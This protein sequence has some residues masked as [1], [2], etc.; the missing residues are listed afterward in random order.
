MTVPG[1]NAITRS[2]IPVKIIRW[3]NHERTDALAE[4]IS[5]Y[6]GT[7]HL[8]RSDLIV[9]PDVAMSLL[10]PDEVKSDT[11][12]NKSANPSPFFPVDTGVTTTVVT[13]DQSGLSL[14][15]SVDYVDAGM[16]D[17]S[18]VFVTR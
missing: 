10:A 7:T 16:P 13:D 6:G 15:M 17:F 4:V 5:K 11:G 3:L 1:S 9:D 8:L 12:K 18:S 2:G 14:S